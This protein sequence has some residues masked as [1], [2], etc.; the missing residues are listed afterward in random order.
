MTKRPDPASEWRD[1]LADWNSGDIAEHTLNAV[2]KDTRPDGAPLD[3]H[4]G[5]WKYPPPE[6]VRNVWLVPSIIAGVFAWLAIGY[7]LFWV[8]PQAIQGAAMVGAG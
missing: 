6:R 5:P 1:N 3:Y 2:N 4:S 7:L 8:L